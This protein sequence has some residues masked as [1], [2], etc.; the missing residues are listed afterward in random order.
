MKHLDLKTWTELCSGRLAPDEADYWSNH[1]ETNCAQCEQV[2][3]TVAQDGNTDALDGLV[4]AALVELVESPEEM[5]S[6]MG[7]DL[8]PLN[9]ARLGRNLRRRRWSKRAASLAAAAAVAA[10]I[11]ML[12]PQTKQATWRNKGIAA[13]LNAQLQILL[14][15][16]NE[17]KEFDRDK[18]LEIGT[19]LVFAI[20]LDQPACVQLVVV[21][22]NK[23]EDQLDQPKCLNAGRHVLADAH[24][25]LAY[26]LETSGEI[27]FFLHLRDA[28]EGQG[29]SPAIWLRV[30]DPALNRLP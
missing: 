5:S 22:N 30:V 20:S 2:I 14:A 15:D 28:Q 8:S 17:V 23:S 27:G 11:L 16:G 26:R 10:G 3:A 13:P 6:T 12:W 29:Q 19:G 9:F 24:G 4:D 25:P 7:E 18:V 1:L 21:K